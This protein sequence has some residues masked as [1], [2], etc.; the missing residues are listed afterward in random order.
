MN[1]SCLVLTSLFCLL[2]G[3]SISLQAKTLAA[4][5]Y[6]TEGGWGELRIGKARQGRQ[7]FSINTATA[8]GNLCDLS[9]II[10]NHQARLGDDGRG[11]LCQVHFIET[12]EGI[13][14][15]SNQVSNCDD[16]CGLNAYF[17]RVYLKTEPLCLKPNPIRQKFRQLYEQKQYQE[18]VASLTPLL[19]RCGNLM[20]P[21]D[22]N[23][24]RNDLAI[25]FYHLKRRDACLSSLNPLAQDAA[26]SDDDLRNE[27]PV[28]IQ[29]PYL[30]IIKATRTN[31]KLCRSLPED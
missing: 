29:E 17:E 15:D 16:F 23:W 11:M 1:S 21:L 6:L 4:G 10:R 8:S 13:K 26:R 24:I 30:R 31:Q 18:A 3:S 5:T 22:L 9:G 12:P 20:N 27:L 19:E 2:S 28:L 14:V 25:S 7:D